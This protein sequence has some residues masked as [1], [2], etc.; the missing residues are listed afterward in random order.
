M[1]LS[2]E[3]PDRTGAGEGAGEG[4][5]PK[6]RF[7]SSA[8]EVLFRWPRTKLALCGGHCGD[9]G[10]PAGS[11]SP[12]LLPRGL[13]APSKLPAVR[14][15]AKTREGRGEKR[16]LPVWMAAAPL[17]WCLRS[18][19]DLSCSVRTRKSCF[20]SVWRQPRGPWGWPGR[21][22]SLAAGRPHAKRPTCTQIL[23]RVLEPRRWS[24]AKGWAL[25]PYPEH[26]HC[27]PPHRREAKGRFTG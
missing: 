5:E 26:R 18:A 16:S 2:L 14:L 8:A 19:S 4:A 12:Q 25:C 23:R 13:Q 10:C 1:F 15:R 22:P 21:W 3:I 6:G 24:S 9:Q 7:L 20:L 11:G 27:P 17:P